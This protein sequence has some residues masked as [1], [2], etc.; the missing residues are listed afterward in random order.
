MRRPGPLGRAARVAARAP[1]GQ[2]PNPGP[3]GLGIPRRAYSKF[4]DQ[5]QDL[6]TYSKVHTVF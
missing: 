2:M 5:L 1:Q 3:G 6:T 4:V